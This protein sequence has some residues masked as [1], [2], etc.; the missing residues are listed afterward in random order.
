MNK[1]YNY[2]ICRY[3]Y[4]NILFLFLIILINYIIKC[5]Y[6]IYNKKKNNN[7]FQGKLKK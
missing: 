1:I 3:Y 6:K 4:K 2:I 5:I 7:D